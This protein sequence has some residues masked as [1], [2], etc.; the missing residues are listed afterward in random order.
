[1]WWPSVRDMFQAA[2]SLQT[3]DPQTLADA[4]SAFSV[5]VAPYR[6]D[7]PPWFSPL[8]IMQYRAQGVP[9]VAPDIGDCS[10]LMEGCGQ[11]VSADN[12]SVAGC[13][14]RRNGKKIPNNSAHLAGG[15]AI[16]LCAC[17]PPALKCVKLKVLSR[18]PM[19]E[20]P[21]GLQPMFKCSS[22]RRHAASIWAACIG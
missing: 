4:V 9:I 18:I 11:L 20:Q 10:L 12:R 2:S 16:A 8:K 7:A 14:S 15:W 13:H 17:R 21:S 22:R 5:A 3:Y 6:S 1:M 19:N